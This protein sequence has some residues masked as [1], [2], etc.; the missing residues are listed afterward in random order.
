[1]PVI[2]ISAGSWI[3]TSKPK[4]QIA[5]ASFLSRRSV[6]NKPWH[7]HPTEV[8]ILP[9]GFVVPCK[10]TDAESGSRTVSLATPNSTIHAASLRSVARGATGSG[11]PWMG[12]NLSEIGNNKTEC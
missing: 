3:A 12:K 5:I 6:R 4:Q 7:H 10:A 11:R 2:T 9:F 8:V 1:M